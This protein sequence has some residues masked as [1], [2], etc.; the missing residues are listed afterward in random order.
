MKNPK[1]FKWICVT[2]RFHAWLT[3]Q[4]RKGESYE[5]VL[6]RLL[7]LPKREEDVDNKL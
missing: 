2:K 4:G 6:R 1:R 7:N 5:D 3:I